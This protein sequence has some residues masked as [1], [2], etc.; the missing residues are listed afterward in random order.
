M[1]SV[2]RRFAAVLLAAATVTVGTAVALA[3]APAAA[4]TPGGY[5][6]EHSHLIGET[7]SGFH[8]YVNPRAT[9]H[10]VLART[11]RSVARELHR[12]GLP[13]WYAGY[14]NP[15]Q[16][17]GRI[18]VTSGNAGCSTRTEGRTLAV[19]VSY[20]GHAAGAD[21]YMSHSRIVVCPSFA[22]SASRTS[23]VSALKH[24]FGHAMGLAHATRRYAGRV[25]IM[26]PAL[27]RGVTDYQA[28]DRH[29]LRAMAVGTPRV[30]N[31]LPP[32]GANSSRYVNG[33]I[34]FTGW[35]LLAHN[36]SRSVAVTVTDNGRAMHARMTAQVQRDVN[37]AHRVSGKH[38]FTFSIPWHGGRHTYCVTATSSVNHRARASLG[39]VTWH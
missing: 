11:A 17:D 32:I 35:T 27:H 16:S 31:E 21:L 10:A 7:P 28:G 9:R 33:L 38:G 8:V 34:V 37:S 20:Y 23:M 4:G 12:I 22:R 30:R 29:G 1:S 14:G 39:C 18:E 6:L 25:Q 24:E 5:V 36:P 3:P 19:T 15:A 2:S 26:A 13:V